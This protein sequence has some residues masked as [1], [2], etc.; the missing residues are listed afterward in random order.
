MPKWRVNKRGLLYKLSLLAPRTDLFL[1]GSFI[2]GQDAKGRLLTIRTG[3]DLPGVTI[4]LAR[5]KDCLK[6]VDKEMVSFRF[7]KNKMLFGDSRSSN[8]VNVLET[9]DDP[10]SL[11]LWDKKIQWEACPQELLEGLSLV[12]YVKEGPMDLDGEFFGFTDPCLPKVDPDRDIAGIHVAGSSVVAFE[13]SRCCRYT[14]SA[15]VP[16]EMVLGT[17][18]VNIASKLWHETLLGIARLRYTMSDT[19]Y[20]GIAFNFNAIR[21][22]S[23]E[24]QTSNKVHLQ[25]QF[26]TNADTDESIVLPADIR[27]TVKAFMDVLPDWKSMITAEI[28]GDRIT[29]KARRNWEKIKRKSSPLLYPVAKAVRL[30][31]KIAEFYDALSDC[32]M[33]GYSTED[34]KGVLKPLYLRDEKCEHMIV[35]IVKGLHDG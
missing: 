17:A 15:P 11:D 28:K 35:A 2:W 5:L 32:G 21:V 27:R 19:H 6:S 7:K 12:S 3:K 4:P 25:N 9:D 14:L 23:P 30:R 10:P 31:F 34:S 8:S 13:W 24:I 16:F 18:V 33:M 22:W 1:K 29:F 20:Q 26:F